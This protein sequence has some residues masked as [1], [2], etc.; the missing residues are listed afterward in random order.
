MRVKCPSGFYC[1]ENTYQPIF[2]CSGYF[3]PKPE[4]IKAC[5][6]GSY[7][8]QGS[9]KAKTCYFGHC[10]EFSDRVNK[11]LLISL[12]L[13]LIIAIWIV[14]KIK[15]RIDRRKVLKY[16]TRMESIAETSTITHRKTSMEQSAKT[17]DIQFENLGLT[18]SN[19]VNVMQV[20]NLTAE[21]YCYRECRASFVQGD[22]AQ[23]WVLLEQEK[24]LS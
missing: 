6:A 20:R 1:P 4:T 19:G 21:S 12:F 14:W 16:Q 11:Y 9:V 2:C 23:L 18:L 8:Q 17:F 5:P 10:D 13:F 22:L 3:C 15:D 7:C 24:P